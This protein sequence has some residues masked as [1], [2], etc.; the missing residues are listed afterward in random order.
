[1]SN[2]V[3]TERW[4]TAEGRTLVHYFRRGPKHGR[5]TGWWSAACGLLTVPT[6]IPWDTLY[7]GGARETRRCRDV[8]TSGL[9]CGLCLL[10]RAKAVER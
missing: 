1:M 7:P 10:K 4:G 2:E 3:L 6:L 5:R 8:A 9:A